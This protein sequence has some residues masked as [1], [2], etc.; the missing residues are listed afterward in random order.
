[1]LT[2][3]VSSRIRVEVDRLARECSSYAEEHGGSCR[4][5]TSKRPANLAVLSLVLYGVSY[6]LNDDKEPNDS[7][8]AEMKGRR[9]A[10]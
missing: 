9:S 1:M 2:R 7:A 3:S 8:A 10:S 5:R 6:A 4:L